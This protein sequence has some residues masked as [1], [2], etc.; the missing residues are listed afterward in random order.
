MKCK[1]I[2]I[3]FLILMAVFFSTSLGAQLTE[4]IRVPWP[5]FE[6]IIGHWQCRGRGIINIKNINPTGL[7][8]VHYFNTEPVHVTQAQAARDGKATRIIIFLRYPD[9]LCCTYNLTYD[10][11]RDQQKGLF[12]RKGSSK[13]VEVVFDR[14]GPMP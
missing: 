13:S 14:I 12:W 5:G 4:A 10:P 7:M 8:E 9:S 3:T 11:Q 6:V 1:T 2:C